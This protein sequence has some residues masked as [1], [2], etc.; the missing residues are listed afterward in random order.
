MPPTKSS[1]AR[2]PTPTPSVNGTHKADAPKIDPKCDQSANQSSGS[3]SPPGECGGT[4]PRQMGFAVPVRHLCAESAYARLSH[5]LSE[6][7]A[8]V[9][10]EPNPSAVVAR[11]LREGS[12]VNL[13]P[14]L[15]YVAR[16][17]ASRE[18]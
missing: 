5:A 12:S 15:G 2:T 18:C 6:F 8:A 3:V 13:A 17:L 7:V 14:N 16:L 4:T 9:A 10:L 11:L 1:K